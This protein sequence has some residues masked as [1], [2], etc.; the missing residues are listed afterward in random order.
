MQQTVLDNINQQP[1]VL[2]DTLNRQDIFVAPFVELFR[3]YDIKKV[4][5]FGSGTSYNVSN[6]AAYYF[7]HIAGVDAAAHYPTVFKNYEKPDWSGLLRNDQV[8]FVGISQSGTS[9]STCEIMA[10]AQGIGCPTLAL[11]GN[12]QSEITRHV[13]Q[14][15]QLLVGDELTPP[16]T[17]GYTVSVLSVYLWAIAVAQAKGAYSPEK[18]LQAVCQAQ[19]VVDHF[20]QV[21]DQSKAWYERN[22]GSLLNSNRI[23]VLGYGVDYGSMLEGILKIGEMLRIPT[24]G[25]E[26]EEYSHGPTMALQKDQTIL[27]IGSEEAE[28]DRMLQFRRIFK[29]YT[30]RIHVITCREMDSDFRD[31][32]FGVKADRY[33]APLLYTVPFQL[34]AAQGAKDIFIDTNIDPFQEPLS[35]YPKQ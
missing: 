32:V 21:L 22:K 9:V 24:L 19:L 10:Y 34:L 17:K 1:A 31:V 26:L 33:L 23:I 15:V 28:F 8:L 11:T 27:M 6:I 12:L 4:L 18:Y 5:F 13:S 14:S 7:K 2:K 3:R 30:P 25:Y 20:D 29:K 16:E 35:H